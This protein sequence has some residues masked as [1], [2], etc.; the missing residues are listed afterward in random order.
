M[1]K[2]LFVVV[3]A[4]VLVACNQNSAEDN[5]SKSAPGK[6]S[7]SKLSYAYTATYSSQVELGAHPEYAQNALQAWKLLEENKI[8]EIKQYFADTLTFES[9]EGWR[10]HGPTDSM[11]AML[12]KQSASLDSLRV[13]IDVWQTAHLKDVNA[14]YVNIWATERSY[15]KNGKPD[16]TRVNENW[17]VRDGKFVYINQYKSKVSH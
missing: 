5:T 1:K 6:D 14:D 2:I 17:M 16:T 8:D 13:D 15:P 12:K 10:F 3:T 4:F 9:A 11:L 7:A